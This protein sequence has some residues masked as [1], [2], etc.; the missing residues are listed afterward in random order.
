MT[1]LVHDILV[2]Y[3]EYGEGML[4]ISIHGWPVDH[5]MMKDP[6]EPIFS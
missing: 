1:R 4:V 3:E 2:Y 6:I 5:R